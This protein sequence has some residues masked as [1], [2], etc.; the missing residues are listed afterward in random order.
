MIY[1]CRLLFLYILFKAYFIISLSGQDLY[2]TDYISEIEIDFYDNTWDAILD[3]FMAA[4]SDERI[5]ADVTINGIVYDS[6]GVRYKGN[7]SFRPNAVKNPLNIKLNYVKDHDYQGYYTLKLS[8]G[9]KDPSFVREVLAWEIARKYMP[10]ARSAYANVTINGTLIGLYTNVQSVN[11]VFTSEHYY[12]EDRPF[13]EGSG[14]GPSP[15]GCFAHIWAYLGTDTMTCY[16]YYYESKSGDYYTYL[17]EFLNFFN[18]DPDH[19][20]AVYNVD[21][22]LWAMAF[23]IAFV[24]LDG[25]VSMPHN[26]YLYLDGTDRF[27][28]IKWDMNEC[29]GVFQ[30]L[31]NDFLD[32]TQMQQLDPYVN[33]NLQSPILYN[34]WQNDRW[35]KMYMAHMVTLMEENI[36]NNWYLERAGELQAGISEALQNDPNKSY[37][38]A[39]SASN[40]NHSVG[41]TVG[42]SE[43]M[44]SRAGFLGSTPYF[45]YTRPV[46]SNISQEPET[47]KPDTEV[48][49][50][51]EI[52][53]AEYS[54]LGYRNIMGGRFK[55]TEMFDDGAHNDG[56]AGDGV[57]GVTIPV[58][59]TLIEYYIYAENDRAGIFSPERAEYEFYALNTSGDLV[60]NEFMASNDQTVAD[61]DSEYDDWIELYNTTDT[62]LQMAG[63]Y[64]SDDV[65]DPFKWQIPGTTIKAYSYL[66]I[67]AD[68]DTLQQGLH[69]NF[70]LS[71]SGEE[72]IL[73]N[74]SGEIVDQV[75]FSNQS[76]DISYGRNPNGTGIFTAMSPTFAAKNNTIISATQN[77][78]RIPGLSLYPNPATDRLHVII[79][80]GFDHQVKIF[81]IFGQQI[82]QRQIATEG[83][84]DISNLNPG[85]YFINVDELVSKKFI[86]R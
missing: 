79:D 47:I 72:L 31:R 36:Y 66:I 15:P 34:V 24:N 35:R 77:Q 54:F 10:S 55:K 48:D 75:L 4:D 18:N 50:I 5:L 33:N 67:W 62:D 46:I 44:D 80:E 64:L 7:S 83:T 22:H 23:D 43:L 11:D 53:G 86:K 70:K 84:I 2:D 52:S 85:I 14:D 27:N 19:M 82:G 12:S 56:A 76:T 51:A 65:Q 57:W 17:M 45:Q 73:S 61:Q 68:N 59:G 63:Y 8:N 26:F 37:S 69:T 49:I 39:E 42:I 60:I 74:A 13:F 40:I 20:E 3:G 71:A 6:A 9:F 29:F 81:N 28:Y 78:C 1:R 41:K 25:P 32:I 21:R 30:Q 58:N 38:V 16:P